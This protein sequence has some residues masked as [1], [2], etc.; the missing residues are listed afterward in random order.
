MFQTVNTILGQEY[1]LSLAYSLRPALTLASSGVQIFINDVL[2]DTLSADGRL[3]WNTVWSIHNYS[4]TA[5]GTSATIKFMATGTSD[6]MGGF[7]DDVQFSAVPVPST[8]ILFGS[9]LAGLIG[10]GRR[11][12]KK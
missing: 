8:M 11:R 1:N 12:L 5:T 4:Y 3:H 9:G 2:I 7:I 6:G 10:L